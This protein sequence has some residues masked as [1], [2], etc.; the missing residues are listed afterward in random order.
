MRISRTIVAGTVVGLALAAGVLWG[1]DPQERA[2]AE[3]I[4]QLIQQLGVDEFAEREAASRELDGMGEA[5]LEALRAATKDPSYEVRWRAQLLLAAPL[6]KSKSTGLELVLVKPGE[7]DMGSPEAE[8]GRQANEKQHRV[9]FTRPYYLGRH[10]VTQE[11]YLQVMK[12]NPSGFAAGGSGREKVAGLDTTR[13]P[14]ENVSWYDAAE[15][16]N[17]LGEL[18]GFRPY[19]RLADIE[20]SSEREGGSI[21]RA[22]VTTLGGYG[23][24]LPTEAEWEFACRAGTSSIYH[25]G[26]GSNGTASNVKGVSIMGG[27]GGAVVG[28]NLQRTAA[29]GSY[30]ANAWGLFDMHGNV[31]EWCDDWYGPDHYTQSQFTDPPGPGA[32]DQRIWRGGAWLLM[33]SSCRSATRAWHTPDE[34][35]DYL[36][37]RLARN[38]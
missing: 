8:A 4:A 28:P 1:E 32:G 21:L 18:D 26:N 7:F 22:A 13:F 23:Y 17:K 14:V 2:R 30:P 11:Q 10:E 6:R 24:R 25:Y 3:R 29:V 34:R 15:F 9:R 19:Y 35:K 37:F 36:G 33:E 12:V 20:R 5:P 38:P 16:C 27:Y 31:G